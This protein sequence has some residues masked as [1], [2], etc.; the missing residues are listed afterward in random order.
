LNLLFEC[1]IDSF[2]ATKVGISQNF[3]SADLAANLKLNLTTLYSDQ[4]LNA[5]GIGNNARFAQND[6]IRSDKI[7]WLDPIHNDPFENDFFAVMDSFVLFLNQTCYTGITNYEFHYAWYEAGSFY[8][9]HIDQFQGN[10]D[11]AFSMIIYLNTD[12]LP[13]HG[14]E[15]CIYH[16]EH[17]QTIAPLNR[18][19]VFFKSSEMPHEVLRTQQ[20]RLSI[21]GWLK[22]G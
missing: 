6:L 19:C 4:Q 21:T 20:P 1:L 18:Q 10:K 3:L 22:T 15:I 17:T 16:P 2:I 13:Q 5:A 12:W 7:Y 11:R 14:G 9:K 8:K